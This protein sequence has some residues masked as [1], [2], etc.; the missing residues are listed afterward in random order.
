MDLKMV[1]LYSQRAWGGSAGGGADGLY[2]LLLG[3]RCYRWQMP[4]I[5]SLQIVP[6]NGS[7]LWLL[8]FAIEISGAWRC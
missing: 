1:K 5:R 8:I 7:V 4:A 2:E 6:A 3:L